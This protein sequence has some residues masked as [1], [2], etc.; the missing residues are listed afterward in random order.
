MKRNKAETGR[1]ITLYEVQIARN[2]IEQFVYF[3]QSAHF[4]YSNNDALNTL[5]ANNC[6]FSE[7][8]RKHVNTLS[9]QNKKFFSTLNQVVNRVTNNPSKN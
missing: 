3:I 7:N 8:L 1:N 4:L 6:T 5:E 9:E 2:N